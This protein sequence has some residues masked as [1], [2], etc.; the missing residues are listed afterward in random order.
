MHR[1][2]SKK[3]WNGL[4]GGLEGLCCLERLGPFW[5]P[6]LLLLYM[7]YP[8]THVI[9]EMHVHEGGGG[10]FSYVHQKGTSPFNDSWNLSFGHIF[11]FSLQMTT[12][13]KTRR[14]LCCVLLCFLF[15]FFFYCF[16]HDLVLSRDSS[17]F[18]IS[19][20]TCNLA[21]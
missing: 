12:K 3:D 16:E 18:L 1:R 7:N 11:F 20:C 9:N 8:I 15:P 21:N 6:L 10:S 4:E 13:E 19:F 5:F 17:R 2:I 14:W